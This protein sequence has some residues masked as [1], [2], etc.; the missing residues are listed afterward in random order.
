MQDTKDAAESQILN[1]KQARRFATVLEGCNECLVDLEAF[2]VHYNGLATSTQCPW[3]RTPHII[4]QMEVLKGRLGV[5]F[6]TLNSISGTITTSLLV[7]Q[8]LDKFIDEVRRGKREGSVISTFSTGASSLNDASDCKTMCKELQDVGITSKMF[9]DHK[10]YIAKTL[11]EVVESGEVQEQI[12]PVENA[13]DTEL[14][15]LRPTFRLRRVAKALTNVFTNPNKSLIHAAEL[16]HF[17]EVRA[18][19]D[20][21]IGADIETKNSTGKT[22][23]MLAIESCHYDTIELLIG[24]DANVNAN[25]KRGETPLTRACL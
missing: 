15:Q 17:M 25:D 9:A 1:S 22:P 20:K 7:Q 12:P 24:Q 6:G 18:L 19:L 8:K 2:V 14:P 21:T 11:Q 23:L 10:K 13:V 4:E 5:S 16:G 3:D